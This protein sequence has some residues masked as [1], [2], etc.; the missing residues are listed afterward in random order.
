M[1][2]ALVAFLNAQSAITTILGGTGNVYVTHAPQGAAFPH[3]IVTQLGSDEF[4]TLDGSGELR[5]MEMDID[6]RSKTSL[7]AESLAAAVRTA[8]KD[9]SGAAGS[10]TIDAVLLN[11]EKMEYL[12]PTDGS[13]QGIHNVLLDVTIMYQPS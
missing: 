12:P 10:E 13:D 5:G 6:C 3:I 1:N 2:A 4:G 8:I 9:Y 11:T 7:Q